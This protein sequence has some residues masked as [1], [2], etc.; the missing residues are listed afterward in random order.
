M[1]KSELHSSIQRII[2]DDKPTIRKSIVIGV[3]GSGMKGVLAALP[4]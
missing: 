2:K 4:T 1:A 3:G